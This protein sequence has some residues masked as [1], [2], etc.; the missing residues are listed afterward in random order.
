[1][2]QPRNVF[3]NFYLGEFSYETFP[4]HLGALQITVML[5]V[6]LASESIRQSCCVENI[7]CISFLLEG[8]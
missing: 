4:V 6:L 2:S 7:F 5:F 1:M 3:C 8:E